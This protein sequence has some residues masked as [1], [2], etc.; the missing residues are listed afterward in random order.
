MPLYDTPNPTPTKQ[1]N[2]CR[3]WKPATTEYFAPARRA[4]Y[5][6]RK[7]RECTG[8]TQRAIS[9]QRDGLKR[10]TKCE[11]WYPP[12]LDYFHASNAH[13][14]GLRPECKI[15]REQ[16]G[17]GYRER[18]AEDIAKRKKSYYWANRDSSVQKSRAYYFQ[19]KDAMKQ[20][21][22]QY[23][24]NNKQ[25][26]WATTREY[27]K[28]NQ[29]KINR[30]MSIVWHRKR[31]RDKNLPDTYSLQDW[32]RALAY[33]NA[34]CAICGCT[35]GPGRT[36]GKDHW[37]PLSSSICPGTIA[38]N[39]VPMCNGRDGCNNSKG[40][41]DPKEWL[42]A[43]YDA[44]KAAAILARIEAYFKWVRGQ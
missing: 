22:A 8:I 32:D 19:N 9:V 2:K 30:H 34:C 37:I 17:K 6:M 20:R 14:D 25:R 27:R 1:C 42:A 24:A 3:E 11:T 7:C 15:C 29:H 12:T 4:E 44:P 10:C 36:I 35:S 40:N 43:R 38:A 18:Y 31:A 26:I 16:Y 39:I 33:F 23:Y 21:S 13:V 28:R 5:L 41:L